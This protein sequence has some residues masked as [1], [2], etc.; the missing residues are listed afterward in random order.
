MVYLQRSEGGLFMRAFEGRKGKRRFRCNGE[1]IDHRSP[2]AA[3]TIRHSPADVTAAPAAAGRPSLAQAVLAV[4]QWQSRRF[5][6][7]YADLMADPIHP[8]VPRAFSWR[9][10]TAR[11]TTAKRDTAIRSHRGHLA[12]GVSA[13]RGADRHRPG[14]TARKP[15]GWT[16]PWGTSGCTCPHPADAALC[17]RLARRRRARRARTSNWPAMKLGKTSP[18]SRACPACA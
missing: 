9:S 7:T 8:G 17:G 6:G 16:T 3:D 13:G 5:A 12:D 14:A 4:K 15:S 10:C 11:A 2:D 18:A 1:S